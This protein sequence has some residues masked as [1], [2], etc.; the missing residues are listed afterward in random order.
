MFPKRQVTTTSMNTEPFNARAELV[1]RRILS[2]VNNTQ[3]IN[4]RRSREDLFPDVNRVGLGVAVEWESMGEQFVSDA[5]LT[6]A[7]NLGIELEHI[8]L[9]L[10]TVLRN[11]DLS[12]ELDTE[13]IALL[14]QLLLERKVIFFHDQKLGSKQLIKF[15]RYFG[16]LDAFPFSVKGDNPLLLE[17]DHDEQHPGNQN[18]WHTDV[19]WM[20]KPSL[21]SVAQCVLVP[22]VGGD[23]LFSDSH[24]VYQGL[25]PK[26]Q[27][28]LQYLA[29]INDYRSFLGNAT[30][31]QLPAELIAEIKSIIP[32]GVSHPLLR[33]HPE[34]DK[35][36]LFLHAGFLRQDSL[37]DTRTGQA[38]D[39]GESQKIIAQIVHQH[40][41]PE[42]TCRFTWREGSVA[43]WDNRAVQHYANSDYY[44][45]RRILQRVAIS[46]DR[47]YYR[48]NA[49]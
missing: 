4:H 38:M 47:P 24:A 26:L 18:G 34:T 11:I 19:T 3:E 25:A 12:D 8:G 6:R 14:H 32:F 28:S 33:T 27:D 41:R 46:G 10:G 15:A 20:E 37:Y 5:L 31:K 39:E 35:T 48:P 43:F 16:E 23:T 44:P 30:F 36:G 40:A 29:G 49:V 45:H 42:Y 21:G 7:R 9:T 1:R 17:L 2:A 13:R 22:P